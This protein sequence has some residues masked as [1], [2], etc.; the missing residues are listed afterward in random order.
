[1][2]AFQYIYKGLK[3][4]IKAF[5]DY[6]IMK[7]QVCLGNKQDSFLKIVLCMFDYEKLHGK[8]INEFGMLWDD[9]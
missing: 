5:E 8:G 2:R 6:L 9:F 1:M 7:K 3:L 4:I